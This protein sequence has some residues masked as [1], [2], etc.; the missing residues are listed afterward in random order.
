MTTKGGLVQQPRLLLCFGFCG[1]KSDARYDCGQGS[2]Y[3]NLKSEASQQIGICN[4][5]IRKKSLPM[6][7][8]QRLKDERQVFQTIF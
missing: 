3:A 8:K 4:L 2:S 7:L 5:N 6:Q 1:A